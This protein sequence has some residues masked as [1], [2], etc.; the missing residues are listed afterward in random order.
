MSATR[1]PAIEEH[2]SALGRWRSQLR[3]LNDEISSL[4]EEEQVARLEYQR[5]YPSKRSDGIGSPVTELRRKIDE[6]VGKRDRL[7]AD[8]R[9]KEQLLDE[10]HRQADTAAEERER[11]ENDRAQKEAVAQLETAWTTF[12]ERSQDVRQAWQVVADAAQRLD[13]LPD[14]PP[15]FQPFPRDLPAALR[16]ALRPGPGADPFNNDPRIEARRIE[17]TGTRGVGAMDTT[18]YNRTLSDLSWNTSE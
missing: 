6:L 5:Q 16:E 10:L 11:R 7:A 2:T 3:E 18:R 12:V 17:T 9:A 13:A 15:P 4:V 14:G 8:I 1:K